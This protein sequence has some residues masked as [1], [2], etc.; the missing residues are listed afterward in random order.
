MTIFPDKISKLLVIS[1]AHCR[2]FLSDPNGEVYSH[3]I[4]MFLQKQLQL[5]PP[6]FERIFAKKSAPSEKCDLET[7]VLGETES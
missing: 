7:I 6:K 5:E 2:L 1:T 4:C 3:E